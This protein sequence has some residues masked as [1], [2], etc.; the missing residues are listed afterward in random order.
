MFCSYCGRKI[1]M[2]DENEHRYTVTHRYI[3]EAKIREIEKK[4]DA[5]KAIEI[6]FGAYNEKLPKEKTVAFER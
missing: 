5:K 2:V 3:D 1:M 6:I 4:S